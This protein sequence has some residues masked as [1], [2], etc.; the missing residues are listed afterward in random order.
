MDLSWHLFIL[1]FYAALTTTQNIIVLRS[2]VQLGVPFRYK[3]SWRTG[4][5][6][7]LPDP[8]LAETSSTQVRRHGGTR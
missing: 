6:I 1:L 7:E 3:S 2:L 4:L 5:E 8:A